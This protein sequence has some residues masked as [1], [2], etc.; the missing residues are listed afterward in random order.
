MQTLC[1]S[2]ELVWTLAVL[3][4]SSTSPASARGFLTKRGELVWDKLIVWIIAIV[5]L[6][7]GILLIVGLGD[8]GQGAIEYLKGFFSF[9]G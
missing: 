5:V 2:R 9:G 4:N 6:V 8:K 7:L 1:F 3:K